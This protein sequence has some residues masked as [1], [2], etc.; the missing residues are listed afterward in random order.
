MMLAG[1][2]WQYNGS[3]KEFVCEAQKVKNIKNGK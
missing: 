2:K 1:Y 3:R